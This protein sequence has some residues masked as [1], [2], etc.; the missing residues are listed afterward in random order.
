MAIAAG[1]SILG[2]VGEMPSGP[3]VAEDDVIADIAAAVPKS[4]QTFFLTSETTAEGVIAY[5]EKVQTTAIQLVDE[6]ESGALKILRNA[7]PGVRLVQVLHVIDHRQ[8]EEAK[9][10]NAL[11]DIFLLD[12][13]NPNLAIKELGGTGR[14]HNWEISRAIVKSVTV[15]TFLAGGLNPGNV[16]EA[17]HTVRPHGVDICSG[18]RTRGLLN[19]EK[20]AS[21]FNSVHGAD[22]DLNSGQL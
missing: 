16:A 11:V 21:F 22:N 2:L 15:P 18:L 12:S 6:M 8:L 20:V 5:Y 13:G 1:A 14:T 19:A 3:G 9:R 7:L 4:I 10:L 17:I